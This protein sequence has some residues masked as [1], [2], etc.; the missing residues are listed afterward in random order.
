[1]TNFEK[2]YDHQFIKSI[3][4]DN[5]DLKTIE[6]R[7]QDDF[8]ELEFYMHNTMFYTVH[9][10]SLLS[11][12]ENSIEFL[13]SYNYKT[14]QKIS[15]GN[16]LT[17]NVENYMIRVISITDRLLQMINAVFYLQVDERDV[18]VSTILKHKNLSST[19]IPNHFRLLNIILKEYKDGRNSIVHRHSYIDKSLFRIEQ[20]YHLE[21]EKRYFDKSSS[22]EIKNFKNMRR[23]LLRDFL[24]NIKSKF[25]KTNNKCFEITL[26]IFDELNKQYAIK[27]SD[28]K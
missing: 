12:L 7:I 2:L 10:L 1:M 20:F 8:S 4:D 3:L 27:K 21:I 5:S 11:Q 17:Y 19:E 13:S 26:L 24:S 25:K 22:E 18:K 6:N 9:C 16:H 15:R 28:L 23:A 14:K